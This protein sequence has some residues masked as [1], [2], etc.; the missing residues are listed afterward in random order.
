MYVIGPLTASAVSV[1]SHYLQII[2]KFIP[3]V[4]QFIKKIGRIE[5]LT[6]NCVKW[7]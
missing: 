2:F 1:S 5:S 6:Q 7:C 3:L 4:F